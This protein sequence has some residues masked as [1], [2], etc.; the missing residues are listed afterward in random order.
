VIYKK[1]NF[2]KYNYGEQKKNMWGKMGEV[3]FNRSKKGVLFYIFFISY[4]CTKAEYNKI[5]PRV[6]QQKKDG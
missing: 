2:V 5:I 1:K 4:T 6:R 3:K